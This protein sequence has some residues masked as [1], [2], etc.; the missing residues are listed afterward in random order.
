MRETG[1]FRTMREMKFRAWDKE[2]RKMFSENIVDDGHL[3]LYNGMSFKRFGDCLEDDCIELMQFT[4]LKDKNGKEIF[5]GDIMKDK[6]CIDEWI[7]S[8]KDWLTM[9]DAENHCK[10]PMIAQLWGCK[11]GLIDFE[12]EVKEYYKKNDKWW[13]DQCFLRDVVWPIAKKDCLDFDSN[14]LKDWGTK[15]LDFPPHK[16]SKIYPRV[17]MSIIRNDHL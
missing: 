11:G 2:S 9:R 14:K 10:W 16:A 3:E 4:G 15:M 6:A 7:K 13:W 12:K 17:G 8:G 1:G 5:E